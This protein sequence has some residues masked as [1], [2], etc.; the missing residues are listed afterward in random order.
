[1]IVNFY[2]VSFILFIFFSITSTLYLLLTVNT[3]S[4][5]INR[6]VTTVSKKTNTNKILS[7]NVIIRFG[8]ILTSLSVTFLMLFRGFDSVIWFGHL[9]ISNTNMFLMTFFLI[10]FILLFLIFL[11]KISIVK[12]IQFEYFFSII[13]LNT[14]L[15]LIFF[16]TNILTFFFILEVVSCLILFKFIVGRDWEL[17]ISTKKSNFFNY[18]STYKSTSYI[19]IVF[20]QYWISFFSSVL[21]VY[22]LLMFLYYYGSTEWILLNF[23]SN[24]DFTENSLEFNINIYIVYIVFLIGFF[25]KL[26]VAPIHF[27]KI[28]LYKGLPFLTILIYTIYFFLIFFIFFIIL[29]S[30]YLNSINIIWYNFGI[31]FLSVGIIWVMV[32][33]FDIYSLKAFFAYSTIVNSMAFLSLTISLIN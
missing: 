24:I 32:L 33:L 21:L 19:N 17:L 26:G 6:S 31:L 4:N 3:K 28:E 9:K 10:L 16:S 13:F 20:F 15:P 1:M 11:N 30:L 8:V 7:N 5:S 27:Y 25:L 12:N 14:L 22:S 23:L 2:E 18:S 29:I